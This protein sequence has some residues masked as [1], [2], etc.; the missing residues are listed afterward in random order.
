M[1]YKSSGNGVQLEFN[2]NYFLK[3]QNIYFAENYCQ[4][5]LP[6][7]IAK[8]PRIELWLLL[9]SHL[10]TIIQR[11]IR[12]EAIFNSLNAPASGSVCG[13]FKSLIGKAG[14]IIYHMGSKDENKNSE[15]ISALLEIS[16]Y[17]CYI[18]NTLLQLCDPFSQSATQISLKKCLA[19]EDDFFN[20]LM[21]IKSQY[22]SPNQ[23]ITTSLSSY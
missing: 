4:K 20:A 18:Y 9:D 21:Q 6:T 7:L 15:L 3:L 19:E 5:R 11:K 14:N 12:L 13:T 2:S 23:L 17:R 22:F 8:I 1:I 16:I 10:K